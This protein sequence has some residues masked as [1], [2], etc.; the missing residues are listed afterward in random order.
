MI[1]PRDEEADY[2]PEYREGLCRLAQGGA[3]VE[4]R[5]KPL[6]RPSG[7]PSPR[8]DGEKGKVFP[9]A[10]R[11]RGEGGAKHRVRGLF[12]L[13]PT[14]YCLLPTAYCLLPNAYCLLPH[15]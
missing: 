11:E 5:E 12:L 13:L 7:A 10:P 14:A 4:R 9:L 15:M 6:I 2:G 3:M 1:V 8:Q